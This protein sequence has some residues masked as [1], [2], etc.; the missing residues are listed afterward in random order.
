MAS[1]CVCVFFFLID[2]LSVGLCLAIFYI[3]L[4]TIWYKKPHATNKK[5]NPQ[6]VCTPFNHIQTQLSHICQMCTV[7]KVL[8]KTC[9][10]AQK[11]VI[12]EHCEGHHQVEKWGIIT[13]TFKNYERTRKKN[14][15]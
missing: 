14:R 15:D 11:G 3:H 7:H 1:Y 6:K 9:P 12:R 13:I 5:K 10:G 8:K 2:T 4:S